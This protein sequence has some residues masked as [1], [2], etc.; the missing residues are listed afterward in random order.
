MLKQNATR[1]IV[2]SYG[3]LEDI[4]IPSNQGNRWNKAGGLRRASTQTTAPNQTQIGWNETTK[5]ATIPIGIYDI[6]FKHI[7]YDSGAGVRG[8]RLAFFKADGSTPAVLGTDYLVGNNFVKDE[9][10][11]DPSSAGTRRFRC[12]GIFQALKEIV[13]KPQLYWTRNSSRPSGLAHVQAVIRNTDQDKL[14]ITRLDSGQEIENIGN[15]SRR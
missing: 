10:F 13:L 9:I 8:A 7:L 2:S 5:E 14:S 12:G 3:N 1:L 4:P 15:E 6:F 11:Y